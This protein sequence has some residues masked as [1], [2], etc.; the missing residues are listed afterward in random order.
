[1]V[2][3]NVNV[4][5]KHKFEMNINELNTIV[6]A[7]NVHNNVTT[8]SCVQKE[9]NPE[10][11]IF[12]SCGDIFAEI[13]EELFITLNSVLGSEKAAY[14]EILFALNFEYGRFFKL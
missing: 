4:N 5:F 7:L 12:C 2:K 10:D 8:I 13:T 6:S 14:E 1:V 9:N 3:Q 11:Y